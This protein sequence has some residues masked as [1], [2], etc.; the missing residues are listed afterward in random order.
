M[1]LFTGCFGSYLR[2]I[3]M[4]L[5]K[6]GEKIKYKFVEL[7][8]CGKQFRRCVEVR[9]MTSAADRVNSR[10]AASV[11]ICVDAVELVCQNTSLADVRGLYA[12][13]RAL[14]EANEPGQPCTAT[15]LMM[16]LGL[17]ANDRY[18]AADKDAALA[19][20]RDVADP[21]GGSF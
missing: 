13:A 11:A 2:Y 5:P 21:A 16:H 15:R 17:D 9:H 3:N 14:S 8:S 1:F 19:T 10:L 4:M 6:L 7:P 12:R 20:L 18:S